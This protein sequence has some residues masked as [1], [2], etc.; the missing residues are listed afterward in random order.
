MDG[1]ALIQKLNM[2]GGA[3][4]VGRT[5]MMEDRVLGLKARENYE[6]P[7]ATILLTAHRDIERIVLTRDELRFKASVDETWSELAYKGLVDEPLFADLNAF[8]DNSQERVTGTVKIRLYKGS[9]KVVARSSPYA[10]YSAE[11]SS[12]DSKAIDQK[13]AEGVCKYHGFQARMYKKMG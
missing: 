3:H 8:I 9:A 5:D 12:F 11:F 1:V 10:L 6:H 2:I 13:D 7:A 4:G